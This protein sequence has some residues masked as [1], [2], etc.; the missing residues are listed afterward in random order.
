MALGL[1]SLKKPTAKDKKDT[2]KKTSSEAEDYLKKLEEKK[3]QN[4]ETCLFC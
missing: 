1:G 3:D 2:S 4:P